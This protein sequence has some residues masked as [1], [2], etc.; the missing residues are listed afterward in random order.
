MKLRQRGIGHSHGPAF[1]AIPE[2]MPF[3]KDMVDLPPASSPFIANIPPGPKSL[4][5]FIGELSLPRDG[6]PAAL[7]YGQ[8]LD[9]MNETVAGQPRDAVMSEGEFAR[10]VPQNVKNMSHPATKDKLRSWRDQGL[11]VDPDANLV[12]P[13]YH[14]GPLIDQWTKHLGE[15]QGR[16]DL[17]RFL[18][19]NGPASIQTNVTQSI[20]EAAK[21]RSLENQ[22]LP[23]DENHITRGD[24]TGAAYQNKLQFAN[25]IRDGRGLSDTAH[26]IRNYSTQ[27]LQGVG[28]GHPVYNLDGTTLATPITMDSQMAEAMRFRGNHGQQLE[29]FKGPNYTEGANVVRKLGDEVGA[30]GADTQAAIWQSYLREKH[31]GNKTGETY[32]DPFARVL[33]DRVNRTA[34]LSGEHPQDVWKRFLIDGD[35]LLASGVP[36]PFQPV[37]QEGQ[38]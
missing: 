11:Y 20:K 22:G 10:K 24:L 13:W 3:G 5:A 2:R 12:N 8:Y 17:K 21:L 7:D 33:E 15:E 25:D 31:A 16:A 35:P 26:K 4:D 28:A 27:N 36:L 9:R 14:P 32:T 30:S 18:E 29:R 37:Q 34:I 38:Q 23:F 1:E 19:Y 6:I